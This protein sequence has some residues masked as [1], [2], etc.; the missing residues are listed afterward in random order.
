MMRTFLLALAWLVS[1]PLL[2]AD[3]PVPAITTAANP[4]LPNPPSQ[5]WIGITP[6]PYG[7][8]LIQQ[9]PPPPYRD[10]QMNRILKPEEKKRWLQMAMP[11][12]NTTGNSRPLAECTVIRDTRS[13]RA[14]QA[15]R[16]EISAT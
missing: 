8:L 16:S 13:L 5:S 10:Y 4:Y 9:A 15:S 12:M 3:P 2:A 7:P 11:M 6:T 1:Q 14:S